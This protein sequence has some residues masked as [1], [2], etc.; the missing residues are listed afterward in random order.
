MKCFLTWNIF[1]KCCS[2]FKG[3]CER[4][5]NKNRAFP[6]NS[7]INLTFFVRS[8][9]CLLQW[10]LLLP[11]WLLRPAEGAALRLPPALQGHGLRPVLLPRQDQRHPA[12][13]VLQHWPQPAPAHH[14]EAPEGGRGQIRS[15]NARGLTGPGLLHDGDNVFEAISDGF[16]VIQLPRVLSLDG[17]I[18]WLIPRIRR[19]EIGYI[20]GTSEQWSQS[21]SWEGCDYIKTK[22]IV[23]FIF[24]E[25][26]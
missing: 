15:L 18:L 20:L 24:Y 21:L 23:L 13:H 16:L 26:N 5:S 10:R 12:Q 2:T 3:H 7:W 11:H 19:G 9:P 25:R 22:F 17:L 6:R 4:F 8:Q 1:I 14:Q